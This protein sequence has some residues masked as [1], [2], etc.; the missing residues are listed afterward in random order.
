MKAILRTRIE[1][2]EAQRRQ[3]ETW[4]ECDV[5]EQVQTGYGDG[6]RDCAG[7]TPRTW[8]DIKKDIDLAYSE[9]GEN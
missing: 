1:A 5:C 6:S 9:K 8:A 4:S 2:L 7:C 3:V